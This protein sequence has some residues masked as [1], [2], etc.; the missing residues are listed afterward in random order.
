MLVDQF[1]DF[2]TRKQHALLWLR[3]PLQIDSRGLEEPID[4]NIKGLIC[5]M[6]ERLP[7]LYTWGSCGGHFYSRADILQKRPNAE[8]SQ[9]MLPREGFIIGFGGDICFDVDETEESSHFLQRVRVLLSSYSDAE[10]DERWIQS[11]RY[12]IILSQQHDDHKLFTEAEAL[13]AKAQIAELIQK[14]T[15]LTKNF[16]SQIPS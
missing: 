5:E 9:L 6:N 7:F 11:Y 2:A 12:H 10:L 1:A 16:C 3:A 15:E 4:E 8:E 14:L 13:R